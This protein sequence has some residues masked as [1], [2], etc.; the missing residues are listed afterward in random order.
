MTSHRGSEVNEEARARRARVAQASKPIQDA[1]N[2][3]M[4]GMD[5]ATI[6]AT[7]AYVMTTLVAWLHKSGVPAEAIHG[8]VGAAITTG[9]GVILCDPSEATGAPPGTVIENAPQPER[10]GDLP[11]AEQA[12]LLAVRAAAS[13]VADFANRIIDR[14]RLTPNGMITFCG[15]VMTSFALALRGL[16]L[17][18]PFIRKGIERSLETNLPVAMAAEE[19]ATGIDPRSLS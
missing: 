5:S 1:M 18:D 10:V 2:A 13:E 3:A 4:D 6:G 16:G 12:P 11:M 8:M 15:Y 17:D 19:E 14:D 9:S 7:G